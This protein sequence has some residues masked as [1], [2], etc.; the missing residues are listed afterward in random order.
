M[1]SRPVELVFG[2]RMSARVYFAQVFQ[3]FWLDLVILVY[4]WMTN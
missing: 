3:F 2:R 1:L 4:P